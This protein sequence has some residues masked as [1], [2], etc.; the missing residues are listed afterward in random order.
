MRIAA[1]GDV[2]GNRFGLESVAQDI[3]EHAPDLWIN[4]GDQLFG[5]A[6]PAGAFLLQRELRGRHDVAEVRG[7][8]DER[9][10]LSP[11]D[12]GAKRGALDWLHEVLP[13]GAGD[14]VAGL[15][16]TR[17][18]LDGRV[19]AAHGSPGSA[20]EYLLL[21]GGRWADDETVTQRLQG[22]PDATLVLVG[23]S[24][25]EHLRQLGGCTVVNVGAVSRQKDGSPLARWA[26]LEERGGGWNVTFRRVPYDLEAAA[27]WAEEHAPFG[28]SEARQLR[29]GRAGRDKDT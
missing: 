25:L 1:F 10:G 21:D 9:L 4:L 22:H 20:W 3:G 28:A 5:G 12:A 16:L 11:G 2:H 23:H 26:L 29:T 14:H 19:L 8:T 6:D 17:T 24:H 18:L 7:N 15:P 27:R 13:A